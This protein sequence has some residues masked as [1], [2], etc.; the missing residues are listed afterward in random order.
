MNK[1]YIIKQIDKNTWTVV[2]ENGEVIST[3]T[4]DIVINYCKKESESLDSGYMSPDGTIDTI[5]WD[6]GDDYGLE[7]VDNYC[8]EFDKFLA[9]F[10]YI[11]VKYFTKK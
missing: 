8:Q 11:C 5:Y 4:K 7:F 3:I 1:R 6:L 9:W 10:D 2:N